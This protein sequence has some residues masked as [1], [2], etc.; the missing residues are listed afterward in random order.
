MY[1]R[2]ILCMVPP[3]KEYHKVFEHAVRTSLDFQPL[4]LHVLCTIVRDERMTR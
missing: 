4:Q 3:L 2:R 1:K